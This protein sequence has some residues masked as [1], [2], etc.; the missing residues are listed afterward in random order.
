[1]TTTKKILDLANSAMLVGEKITFR[2]LVL[3]QPGCGR[4]DA[5]SG[6]L[7]RAGEESLPIGA[8]GREGWVLPRLGGGGCGRQGAPPHASPWGPCAPCSG[9]PCQRPPFLWDVMQGEPLGLGPELPGI[10]RQARV[11]LAR[12]RP[13]RVRAQ[14]RAPP[15]W[16]SHQH[17]GTRRPEDQ[18]GGVRRPSEHREVSLG[19]AKRGGGAS[20]AGSAGQGSLRAPDQAM[21][22]AAPGMLTGP[23]GAWTWV[24]SCLPSRVPDSDPGRGHCLRTQ[25]THLGC[26]LSCLLSGTGRGRVRGEVAMAEQLG[27]PS[28][29]GGTS[30]LQLVR[31]KAGLSTGPE[32]LGMGRPPNSQNLPCKTRGTQRGGLVPP[33][34]SLAAMPCVLG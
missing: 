20:A 9:G 25:A 14:R 32:G 4:R 31:L 22:G 2:E 17:P 10:A 27:R 1:M 28:V 5:A 26:D 3:R 21:A 29:W 8:V 23:R 7:V 30:W 6:K 19:R 12:P 13:L 18:R 33:Q 24:G 34:Y 15:P 16:E 11:W